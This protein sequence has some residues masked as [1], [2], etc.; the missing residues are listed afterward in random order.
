M[1]SFPGD[2]ESHEAR[3]AVE[4]RY[5]RN[6]T[7]TDKKLREYIPIMVVNNLSVLL[8]VSVDGLVLGNLVGKNAL[9]AV[10]IFYPATTII[11]VA[12]VLVGCGTGTSLAVAVGKGDHDALMR[13]KSAV[14]RVMVIAAIVMSVVQVPLVAG[15]ISSYGLDDNMTQMTWQYAMG[16]MIATPFGLISTV[17]TYQFQATGNM[18]WL[19]RL[20]IM[21]GLANLFLDLLFV[22]PLG[23]GVMGASMGTACAN[24]LRCTA[25]VLILAKTTDIYKTDGLKAD[26]AA[27]KDLL[28]SGMPDA[29][30]SLVL[31]LQNYFFM[32]V[33]VMAFG[34]DGGVIKGVCVFCSSLVNVIINGVQGAM[35]PLMGIITGAE[36]WDGLRILFRQSL[37]R[38]TVVVCVMTAIIIVFPEAFYALHGVNDLPSDAELCLRFFALHFVFKGCN[39][40]FRKYYVNRKDTRFASRLTVVANAALPLIAYLLSQ[41]APPAFI[42]LSYLLVETILLTCNLWRYRRWLRRDRE[43]SEQLVAIL[44]LSVQPED[45]VEISRM[46]RDFASE[47]G[48]S[49]RV[50]YRVALCLE[51]MIAYAVAANENASVGDSEN[52]GISIQ[53]SV[54]F[55]RDGATLTILDDGKRIGLDEDRKSLECITN[56]DLVKCIAED[57]SYQRTLDLNYTIMR[58]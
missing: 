55:M 31:A 58:F 54:R 20:S 33:V 56:Y 22:G 8:L 43:D 48:I 50:S 47:K 25:T 17:G 30:N 52:E 11:G 14:K 53:V 40:L 21:E 37:R 49:N 46:V 16:I 32:M 7:L 19:M 39:T 28:S 12:S 36:D 35:L 3:N 38:L 51:E 34:D 41:V 6:G 23:M 29:S 24:A 1:S 4:A 42:W 18:R 2:F 10:N 44:A 26:A 57:V 45:A 15:I 5:R 27:Y 13:L 9:A